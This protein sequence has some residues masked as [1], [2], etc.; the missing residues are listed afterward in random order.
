MSFTFVIPIISPHSVTQPDQYQLSGFHRQAG[1]HPCLMRKH[2]TWKR[3][4]QKRNV[5]F[6][7]RPFQ[8][9]LGPPLSHTGVKTKTHAPK[10]A[11][12]NVIFVFF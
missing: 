10:K 4:P 1:E 3:M 9:W 7:G 6:K 12:S 5:P 8:R 2:L 11:L